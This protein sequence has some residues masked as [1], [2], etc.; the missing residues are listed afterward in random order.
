MGMD[1][2]PLRSGKI[3]IAFIPHFLSR[4]VRMNPSSAL[5]TGY[6]VTNTIAVIMKGDI[7]T[8]YVNGAYLI[9][10]PDLSYT[11]IAGNVAFLASSPYANTTEI[12]FSNLKMY[13]L[14]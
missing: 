14:S 8:L 7:F 6:N 11:Y 10:L 3:S 13:Q 4:K 5:K 1:I 12:V 9:T 2:W